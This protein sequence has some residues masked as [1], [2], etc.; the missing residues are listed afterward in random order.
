MRLVFALPLKKKKKCL[1]NTFIIFHYHI[2]ADACDIIT[3]KYS[4]N[5][6]FEIFHL[7]YLYQVTILQ[8]YTYMLILN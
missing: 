2:F 5:T 8:Y 4:I 3:K 6:S 7:F 1:R